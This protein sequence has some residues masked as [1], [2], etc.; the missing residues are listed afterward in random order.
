MGNITLSKT[1]N[2]EGVITGAFFSQPDLE[3]PEEV[4]AKHAGHYMVVPTWKFAHLILVHAKFGFG[5]FEALLDRPAQPA[6]PYQFGQRNAEQCI[7]HKIGIC[8]F[9]LKRPADQQPDCLP[10]HSM[11]RDGNPSLGKFIL[12]RPLG[13]LG[14]FSPVPEEIV[15]SRGKGFN[16]KRC[17]DLVGNQIFRKLLPAVLIG[18]LNDDRVLEPA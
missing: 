6:Q 11:A 14:D 1:L 15:D 9:C 2:W 4:M 18:L 12:D 17:F 13:A 5:F 3:M 10:R 8:R 16:G 7:G